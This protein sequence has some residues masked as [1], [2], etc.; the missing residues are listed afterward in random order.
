MDDLTQSYYMM[1]KERLLK[2]QPIVLTCFVVDLRER[3][4]DYW[5][6]FSDDI[7]K[8]AT[9]NSPRNT[10]ETSPLTNNGAPS[11]QRGPW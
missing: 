8:S 11:L 5:A 6:P 9:A 1:F 2:Y 4:L 7:H 3:H 10:I